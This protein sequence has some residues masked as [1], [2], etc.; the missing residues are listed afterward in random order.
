[1]LAPWFVSEKRWNYEVMY[2]LQRAEY[3]NSSKSNANTMN[4]GHSWQ[5]WWS[6]IFHNSW[7]VQS[8][9]PGLYGQ[10]FTLSHS[11]YNPLGFIRVAKDTFWTFQFIPSF[12]K[13][14]EQMF[15]RIKGQYM[16]TILR[17]HSLFRKIF[18]LT[19]RQFEDSSIN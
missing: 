11:I 1:M 8:L 4:S 15:I 9:P 3:K 5:S 19:S 6:K 17:G 18:W 2:K 10:R 16:Y 13:I 7:Y 12:P 14:H